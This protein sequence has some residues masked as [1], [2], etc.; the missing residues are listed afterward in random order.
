M[1]RTA[2]AM[3]RKGKE[4]EEEEKREDVEKKEERKKEEKVFGF[5]KRETLSRL[6]FL[7]FWRVH[8]F[9]V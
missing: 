6:S 2:E 5:E 8:P 7:P 9:R 3:K 4:E 1:E